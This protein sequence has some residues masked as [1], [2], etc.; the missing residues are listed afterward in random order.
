MKITSFESQTRS[1]LVYAVLV[2]GL[3]ILQRTALL[4]GG[5]TENLVLVALYAVVPLAAVWLMT[6]R[7]ARVGAIL[8]LSFMS[9]GVVTN[10]LLLRNLAFPS[11]ASPFMVILLWAWIFSLIL[12]QVIIAWIAIAVI[13]ESHRPTP[14]AEPPPSGHGRGRDDR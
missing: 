1:I 10:T 6:H 5:W 12:T 13:K 11:F 3:P 14:P 2:I 9:S 4:T 8:L 7:Q